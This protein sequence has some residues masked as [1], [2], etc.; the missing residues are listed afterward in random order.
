MKGGK[1]KEKKKR[2]KKEKEKREKKE[3][4]NRER[5]GGRGREN[6]LVI[7]NIMQQRR[8]VDD[9]EVELGPVLG[10]GVDVA[11]EPQHAPDVAPVV[12]GVVLGHVGLD[13]RRHGLDEGVV[14]EGVELH[15]CFCVS[16]RVSDSSFPFDF[17]G[18]VR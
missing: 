9:A 4:K 10:A 17:S 15:S 6:L 7:P 14:G 5:E 12:R 11:G 13:V 18:W 2:E 3:R 8:Q 1:K 16:F